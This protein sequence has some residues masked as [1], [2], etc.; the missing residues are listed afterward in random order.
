MSA[1]PNS[2]LDNELVGKAVNALLKFESKK[3]DGS[4][5]KKALLTGYA[6]PILVQVTIYSCMKILVYTL[7]IFILH[8]VQIQLFSEITRAVTKPTRVKIP[9]SLFS[10]EEE[11]NTICLFCRSDDKESIT[12]FLEKNPIEGL[13]KVVSINDAKKHYVQIKDKKQLLKDH[14]HFITDSRIAGQLYNILGSTFSSRNDY[15]VQINFSNPAQLPALVKT[16]ISSTYFHFG[17]KNISI[18]VGHTGMPATH[19]LEN[20][21]EGLPFAIEK[22]QNEWKDVHSIHLKT[23]DS[24]ALPVYSKVP[25]DMMQYVAKAAASAPALATTTPAKGKKTAEAKTVEKAAPKTVEK[26]APKTTEKAPKSAAKAAAPVEA[27]TPAVDKSSKKRKAEAAPE[28]PAAVEVSTAT[29]PA[30]KSALKK[31]KTPAATPAPVA[32]VE[33]VAKA[34]KSAKKT[35]AKA[36]VQE[37]EEEEEEAPRK[38]RA[39]PAKSAAVTPA[40]S[41]PKRATSA[42]K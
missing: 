37:E 1:F 19:V 34:P 20:I 35:P 10:L 7:L 40:R 32:V 17:G 29:T 41:A 11:D 26:A 5:G 13:T 27:V 31:A 8:L 4:N 3:A 38:T 24:A 39:T 15:P 21:L 6:K 25:D 36:V 2:K 14:T 12:A 22:L 42:R 23:S 18:R 30:L 16:V 33:E 9:H 28:T